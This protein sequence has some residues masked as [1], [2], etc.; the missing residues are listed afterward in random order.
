MKNINPKPSRRQ[1]LKTALAAAGGLA[2]TK[3]STETPAPLPTRAPLDITPS[4]S[5]DLPIYPDQDRPLA[6]RVADLVDRMT[7]EELAS[8]MGSEAMPIERLGIPKYN[9]WSE[10]GHGVARAGLATVFPQV[11]GMAATWNTDL[12][13]RAADVIS[14]EGRA[15]HHE[16]V[17]TGD[18]VLYGGLTFFCPNINIFRDPRW[19]RGQETYGEDPHLTARMAVNFIR[20]LQGDD[21][22]YLKTVATPK[23]FAVHSGPEKNRYGFNAVV[24][25]RDL[26]MTYLPAFQACITEAKAGS[27]MSAY[28]RLNGEACTASPA[29]LQKILREEWGFDGYVVSDCGAVAYIYLYHG[30]VNSEEE[31][32]AL[33]VTSGCDLECGCTY[34][35]PCHFNTLKRAALHNLV[36]MEDLKRSVKRLFTARFRLGM[37]DPPERVPYAQIPFS[38]VDSPQH[39][40]AALEAAR[41]SLVLLKNKGNLLPL[42][43]ENIRSIAVIGPNADNTMVLEGNYQGTPAEPV[44]VLAGIRAM[45]SAD[46][47]VRY[48]RGCG[49]TSGSD[50]ET[51]EALQAARASEVVVMVMGLSQQLEGEQGQQEGNPPG[52][53]SMGDRISL[54]LPAV[55]EDLLKAVFNTGKPVILVLMGGSAVAINWADENIPAILEAWYPGQAG[56]TAV[57]EALFGLTNPGGRLPV[58]FYRSTKD[59]PAFDSYEMENRT[60]RY[61]QGDPLYPFGYGLSYTS[62]AYRNLEIT[63][64]EIRS[65]ESVSVQVEVENTGSVAGDEVAQLY[66]TDVEASQPVPRLQLQG[67]TRLHLLPGE[68]QTVRFTITPAQM[69]FAG[70]DGEWILEAGG[71]RVW[72][73]GG[74]PGWVSAGKPSAGVEAAFTVRD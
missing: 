6:E 41:Q 59:L 68:K 25:R 11:I 14:D 72:V 52:I 10:A 49:I 36:S 21:P 2:L 58:T 46:T 19:G 28:N 71:F 39:R 60:Y 31:A 55:Q 33:A 15:K 48:A 69:S 30:L 57:A 67:F 63:P 34:G 50:A 65:G 40:E 24:S 54:N 43:K 20:G 38:V 62:F 17:R 8:Q 32:A 51:E 42:A 29:L 16:F 5:P 7:V 47:A 64:A 13:R 23:H 74:Q 22:H 35:I 45:V 1:F 56:G 12:I 4:V 66:L 18:R 53:T 27:I 44:S 26:R 73:G 3:C 61:F 9:W 37:F 70:E